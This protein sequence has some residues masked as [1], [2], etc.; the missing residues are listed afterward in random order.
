MTTAL[1]PLSYVRP[2]MSEA[3]RLFLRFI[4]GA[5]GIE[6]ASRLYYAWRAGF[7]RY[8]GDAMNRLLEHCGIRLE[9]LGAP[10]PPP[11]EGQRPLLLIAN[12][13]Y[14]VPDGVALLALA[15]RLGRPVR[16]LI[17]NDLLRI[18][19]MAPYSLPIDFSETRAAARVNVASGR[20]AVERLKRGETIAIFPSGGIATAAWPFGRAGDLA[21]KTFVAK[22]VQQAR[23]DVAPLYF[24]GQNSW[25]FHLASQISLFLRLALV[26]P[27]TIRRIGH[28][29]VVSAGAVIPY[30]DMAAIADRFQLTAMLRQRVFGLSPE[31][32]AADRV[33]RL[34]VA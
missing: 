22:L 31:G 30:E 16:I 32:F 14:G 19:E 11:R 4:E 21:W 33:G 8:S 2:D 26:I 6:E 7:P 10:W 25:T 3:K 23:A 12:H 15:E 28:P 5:S 34:R 20:E 13:P 1:S 29:L 24:H 27:E 17:N 18:P 9:V